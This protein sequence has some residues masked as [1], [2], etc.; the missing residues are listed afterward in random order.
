MAMAARVSLE[1]SSILSSDCF[2]FGETPSQEY[3]DTQSQTTYRLN[4]IQILSI[5]YPG[6]SRK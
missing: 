5:L 3:F 1:A 4:S 2:L 6:T